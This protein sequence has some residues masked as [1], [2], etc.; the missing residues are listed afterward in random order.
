VTR[1]ARVGVVIPNTTPATTY[2]DQYAPAFSAATKQA[3][4][5]LLDACKTQ[6][7][8]LA[9]ESLLTAQ[10]SP[11]STRSLE[12]ARRTEALQTLVQGVE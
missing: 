3:G 10:L 8:D 11:L 4:R 12:G 5:A 1:L 2:L 7:F 6:K 9:E